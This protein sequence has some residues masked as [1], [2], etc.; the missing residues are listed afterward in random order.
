MKLRK[1]LIVSALCLPLAAPAF[2]EG[3]MTPA[4]TA[5]VKGAEDGLSGTVTL[6]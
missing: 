4:A 5:D 6:N 2:A 1:T 3:H